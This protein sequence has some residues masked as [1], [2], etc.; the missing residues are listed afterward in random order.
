MKRSCGILMPITALP[1]PYGIGTLGKAAF[2]FVDFLADAGQSWWQLLPVGHTSFG[3]S[4]YQCFST[5]AGNPYLVDLDLLC[6]DG[7]LKPEELRSVSWGEDPQ[8]VDY[9]AIYANRFSLLQ[10]ACQ[11]G[12]DADQKAIAAFGRENEDWLEDYALF[13][14]LK[15]RFDMKPWYEWP[16]EDLRLRRPAAL[17]ACRE[18]LESDVRLFTYIQYLFFK[19]WNALRAYA[20]EKGIG[21]IGDLPIYVALDSADVWADPSGFQLDSRNV[22]TEVS[23]VPPDY[24]NEDGQLWGNHTAS[25]KSRARSS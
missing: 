10:L 9:A 2:S 6:R 5:C 4:P 21:I 15:R 11:R 3:D 24:F 13:M 14:A 17:A 7:L 25:P 8:K 1:S 22:P 23:G 20:R 12:W 16:D 19:Q 18:A